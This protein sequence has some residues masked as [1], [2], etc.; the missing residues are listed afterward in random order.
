MRGMNFYMNILVTLNANYLN[1]LIIM[2]KSLAISNKRRTFDVYVMNNSLTEDNIKYLE[3][4]T[5]KNV[6]IIDLK[7]YDKQLDKAPITKR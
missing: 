5:L 4:N 2:L 6:N 7:I 3:N 1:A